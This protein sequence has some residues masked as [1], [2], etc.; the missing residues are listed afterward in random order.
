MF[1]NA[2]TDK[3]NLTGLSFP[4]T[5]SLT[6][7]FYQA[8]GTTLDLSSWDI[9][10]V[11][12]LQNLIGFSGYKEVN[13]ANWK[14]TKVTNMNSI[15]YYLSSLEKLIIPDW[16]MTNTTNTSSFLYNCSKLS[17][18]DLSRSNDATI[19]K[20]AT[21]VPARK[22]A[23]YG[24]ILIPVDSSQANINALIAKYWKPV[25]P[26]IDMTSTELALELDEIK[27]GETTKLYYGN[28]EPW[29]GNDVNVEYVLS[30]ESI[31]TVDKENMMVV[32][33]GVVGTTEITARIADTQE[34][35]SVAPITL[36]VSETDNYPNVIKF[37]G[38]STPA[39]NNYIKV[40][41]TNVRLSAMNYN[42]VSGIYTYDVGAPITSIQFNGNGSTSYAD[43]CTDVVKID[44]SNMTSMDKMFQH[45]N[46]TSLVLSNFDTSN[47]TDMTY[48]FRDCTNLISLDLSNFNTSN[49]TNMAYMFYYCQSLTS[50]NLSNFDTSKVTSMMYMFYQCSKLHTL[51]LDNCNNATISKIIKAA[52]FPTNAITGVTRKIYCKKAEA[53]GLTAPTNWVFEF[54]D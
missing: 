43:T 49:V 41:G 16:D 50:L 46:L 15:F 25:G 30:D 27:P 21:F 11:T 37:R 6:Y 47:V 1:S 35:I 42:S 54:V 24:Q 7:M 18:I 39:S 3:I 4:K 48:M 44:T 13:L 10:N 22:L 23:T 36:V 40:N 20:I 32:S 38:T 14:T 5:T 26:R 53:A 29:Y 8:K 33:T 34:I 9:S 45:C 31:A 17:Y 28:S 51:R 19:A 2:N 12:D 52:G